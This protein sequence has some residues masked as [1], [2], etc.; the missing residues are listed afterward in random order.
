MAVNLQA[1]ETL[2]PVAGVRLASV[3]AG[4]RYKNRNDLLLIELEQGSH[5][6]AVFTRNAFCA[7]PVHVCRS[8]LQN[9]SPRYLLVNSGNANAGTGDLGMQAA[10]ECCEQLAELGECW[11][12]QVLPFSTGVIGMQLPVEK[13]TAALPEALAKLDENGWLEASR[14]IMTT[15]TVAKAISRQVEVFGETVT[16]TGIAKGA[17]MIH[18][19]M[20]TMLAYVATDALIEKDILQ[21]VLN[22]VVEETFNCITVDGDTSTNDSLV[23]MATGSSGVYVGSEGLPAFQ[24]ALREVCLYLAQ[25]IVRDGEGATKF[26]SIDVQGAATRVEARAVGNT[27]ALSPLVKTA[28]FASDPNWGRILA[29]VGRSPV[30][31]LDVSL[32]TIW[33]GETLLIEKGEPAATYREELGAAETKR[34]EIAIRIDLGRGEASATTWT[35]DF[36]YDYVKINAEY[37]S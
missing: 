14:T 6:V 23:V 37:R 31:A 2:L 29:A 32:I 26:I 16:I 25:A 4:I 24:Q 36:S 34:D 28:L 11:A 19:N 13:I 7:A 18:P 15:D 35:C 8:H 21:R 9:G 20:A 10:R 1:P 3:D 5:T 33:L 12:E 27:V 22:E 30:E 17:G